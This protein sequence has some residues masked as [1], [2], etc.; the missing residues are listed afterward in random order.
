MLKLKNTI[1]VFIDNEKSKVFDNMLD[2]L[3]YAHENAA[4][5][6]V[7]SETSKEYVRC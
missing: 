7:R 4:G 3:S 6:K 2:A 5:K 1:I